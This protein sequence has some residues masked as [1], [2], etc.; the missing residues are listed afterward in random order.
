MSICR[1]GDLERAPMVTAAADALY[2]SKSSST[3]VQSPES[4]DGD[5]CGVVVGF[6]TS[7]SIVTLVSAPK[8]ASTGTNLT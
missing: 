2:F 1:G 6:C 3:M 7:A 8:I 5:Y 4:R